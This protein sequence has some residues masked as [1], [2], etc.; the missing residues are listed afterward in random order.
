MSDC[1]HNV[2]YDKTYEEADKE[3]AD[4]EMISVFFPSLGSN[5]AYVR[6]IPPSDLVVY[7]VA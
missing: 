1:T 5:D 6:D 3:E 7:T 4:L 2:R